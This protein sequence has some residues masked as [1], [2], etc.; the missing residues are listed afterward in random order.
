MRCRFDKTKVKY[1][2]YEKIGHYIK[3]CCNPTRRVKENVNLVVEK[4]KEAT[5]LLVHEE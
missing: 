1:Y 3:D 2:N 5:L 4:K